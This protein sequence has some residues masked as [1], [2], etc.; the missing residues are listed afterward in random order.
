MSHGMSKSER[1]SGPRALPAPA[2]YLP[3][4]YS[5]TSIAALTCARASSVQGH[6]AAPAAFWRKKSPVSTG[7][8]RART[9][10]AV[11]TAVATAVAADDADDLAVDA[12]PTPF[13]PP[14]PKSFFWLLPLLLVLVPFVL[15]E[16]DEEEAAV[17][18][19]VVEVVAVAVG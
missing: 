18:V 5:A 14:G 6:W 11:A 4:C 12:A 16:D 15:V 8:R 3:A 7:T 1:K 13:P 17:A 2:Y 10:A 19:E 9:A